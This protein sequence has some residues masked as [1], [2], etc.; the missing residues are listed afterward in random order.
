MDI[1]GSGSCSV[2]GFGISVAEP[3]GSV[4][5][6]FNNTQCWPVNVYKSSLPYMCNIVIDVILIS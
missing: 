1:T 5:T 4:T 2:V 6:E 3:L